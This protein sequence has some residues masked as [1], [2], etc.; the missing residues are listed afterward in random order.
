[1]ADV[2]ITA[3]PALARYALRARLPEAIE[4]ATGFRLPRAISDQVDG[5]AQ[6]GPAEWYARL[7]VGQAIADAPGIAVVDVGERAVAIV[8][9]GADA[10]RVLAAGC[11]LD[12]EVFAVGR[13]ARTIY[14][15]VE[16]VLF[17]VSATRFEIDVWRSFSPWISQAL[18]AAAAA[19]APA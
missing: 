2:T 19:L 5:I 3:G 8:V 14:E 13:A 6:L 10:W 4:A 7:P 16:I 18:A 1:M 17:R 9:E 11:P 12:L 15:T